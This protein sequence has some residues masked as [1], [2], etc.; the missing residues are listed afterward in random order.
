[1]LYLITGEEH[2]L[3]EALDLPREPTNR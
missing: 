3:T 2:D 1:V